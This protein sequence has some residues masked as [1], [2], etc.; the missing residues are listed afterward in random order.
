M[1][2]RIRENSG[3][4][5]NVV[6]SVILAMSVLLVCWI[7]NKVIQQGEILSSLV[8]KIGDTAVRLEILELHGSRSLETHV[9]DDDSRVA[10]IGV[11]IDKIE[12]AIIALQNAATELKAVNVQLANLKEGQERIERVLEKEAPKLTQSKP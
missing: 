9:K 2:D 6:Q 4:V 8:A 11:R 3:I 12:S 1:T 10:A 5:Y 7:G